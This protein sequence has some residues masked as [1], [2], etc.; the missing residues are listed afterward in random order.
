MTLALTGKALSNSPSHLSSHLN[1][2]VLGQ[3]QSSY[4]V[5]FRSSSLKLIDSNVEGDVPLVC[6]SMV[7][8]HELLSSVFIKNF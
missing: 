7:A 3:S 4:T 8:C 1:T 6:R 2:T 5:C